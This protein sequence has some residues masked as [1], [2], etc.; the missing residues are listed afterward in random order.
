MLIAISRWPRANMRD[1]IVEEIKQRINIVDIIQ[2]YLPLKKAG[3][4]WKGLCPFHGEK[5]PSFMVSEERMNFHC[6]GCG[7]GGDVFTFLQKMEGYEF[8]EV[9]KLL[10]DRAGVE[11]PKRDPRVAHERNLLSEILEISSRYYGKVLSDSPRAEAGR[12]YAAKRGLRPETIRDFGIGFAPDG[13]E[14]LV[15]FLAKRGYKEGDIVNA[16]LA[17][18]AKSGRGIYDRFRKRVMFTIRN[19]QGQAVGFTGR[20]L[21]EDEKKPDAGGKYVN[22][23]ESAVY[24]KGAV[25]FGLDLAKQ[26]I[27]RQD[28][29]V[30]VEGN[31]DVISSHQ[32]GIRNVVAA[33]GTA[34]TDD[35]LRLL[36]RYTHRLSVAF[37]G[38]S[39]GAA[40]AKK[41]I[42]M[43]LQN[44]FLIKV[45]SIPEGAGKDPDDCVRK[46]PELW[47]KAI[48]EAADIMDF[49]IASA[50]KRHE[51]KSAEGKKAAAE[52]IL[53][54]IAK[55][56]DPLVGA[57]YLK[58]LSE[59]VMLPEEVLRDK[60]REIE[61]KS[62]GLRPSG[63]S[64]ERQAAAREGQGGGSA[65][66]TRRRLLSERL[67][68][69]YLTHKEIRK[70]VEDLLKPEYLADSDL[71]GLYAWALSA[72]N[73]AH[74][75]LPAPREERARELADIL[76]LK[77][78]VEPAADPQEETV[79]ILN[80]LASLHRQSERERLE[81]EM[82]EAEKAGDFLRIEKISKAFKEL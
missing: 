45:I 25:L 81:A 61:A 55:V 70:T 3:V 60:L 40:A 80:N 9:L 49:L 30:L 58:T 75:S 59:A 13:W 24:H 68:A 4:N 51:L 34:L 28:S 57:H 64:G 16:G 1:P 22:T 20:L 71:K 36:G 23:P 67:L 29:A 48:A 11:L 18:R 17:V 46:D 39:A 78:G 14:S 74:N 77:L 31:M 26:E 73:Q 76:P 63:A 7:E 43:A 35:Q 8:P 27:R 44:G 69:L 56:S 62:Q 72:Y 53:P 10:A 47:K 66:P 54:V 2:E 37:D 50:R 5:T 41:S 65:P 42:V 52:D 32:A 19:A 12:Q 21:P 79:A 33:S 15:D 82:R 38:D 6:F